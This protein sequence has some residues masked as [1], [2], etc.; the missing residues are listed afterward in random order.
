MTPAPLTTVR[1]T[2]LPLLTVVVL[3]AAVFV[4]AGR[5]LGGVGGQ[6]SELRTNSGRS[7]SSS[8]SPQDRFG[9]DDSI[10]GRPLMACTLT[11][12]SL[13]RR[14]N[15]MLAHSKDVKPFRAST[16]KNSRG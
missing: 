16:C 1:A 5:D 10:L 8:E 7:F 15:P 12:V 9:C 14:E 6:S 2:A 13:Q 4:L 11:L 3:L